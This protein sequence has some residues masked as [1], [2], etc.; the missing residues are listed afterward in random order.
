MITNFFIKHKVRKLADEDRRGSRRSLPFDQVKSV[1]ILYNATDH[2]ALQK[3]F[4]VITAEH[5]QL[6]T[7]LFVEAEL[8]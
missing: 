7:C 3:G 4:K 1:L 6:H 5:K 2:E 8:L